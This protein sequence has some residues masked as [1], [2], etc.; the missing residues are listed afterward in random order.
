VLL[1]VLHSQFGEA[2]RIVLAVASN[3][4]DFARDN[5]R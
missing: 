3:F 5:L 1:H 2:L 4:D